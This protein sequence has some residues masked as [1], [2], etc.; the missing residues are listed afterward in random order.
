MFFTFFLV[1]YYKIFT[2]YHDQNTQ[3]DL[4]LFMF[5]LVWIFLKKYFENIHHHHTSFVYHI[6]T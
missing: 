5:G 4:L 3:S 2:T 6:Y 1:T